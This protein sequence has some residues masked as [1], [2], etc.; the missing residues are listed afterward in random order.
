MYALILFRDQL[1][2]QLL[3][4]LVIPQHLLRNF[5]FHGIV[6]LGS[7]TFLEYFPEYRCEDGTINDRRSIIGKSFESRPWDTR[8]EFIGSIF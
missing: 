3:T 7:K 8:G 1:A 4:S 2:N 5:L 6:Q